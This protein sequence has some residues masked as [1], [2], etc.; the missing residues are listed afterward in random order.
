[1]NDSID[2]ALNPAN[3]IHASWMQLES[4]YYY[5]NPEPRGGLPD[6]YF[7]GYPLARWNLLIFT[8]KEPKNSGRTATLK[9]PPLS[10]SKT[11]RAE[12]ERER[13][14]RFSLQNQPAKIRTSWNN[15]RKRATSRLCPLCSFPSLSQQQINSLCNWPLF[16]NICSFLDLQTR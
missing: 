13:S 12:T 1:M 6:P 11:R 16:N 3:H 5:T 10:S 14:L 4:Y 2:H 8:P 7:C 15:S 9:I